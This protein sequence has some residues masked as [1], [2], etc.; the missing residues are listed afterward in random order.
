M[1]LNEFKCSALLQNEGFQKDFS[2]V[3]Y[4]FDNRDIHVIQVS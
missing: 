4:C 2:Y 3:L 1:M